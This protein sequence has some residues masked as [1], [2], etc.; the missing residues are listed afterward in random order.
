MRG[1]SRLSDYLV[2]TAACGPAAARV[3]AQRAPS[4]RA[5]AATSS[6]PLPC[7]RSRCCGRP[8]RRG[9]GCRTRRRCFC[10]PLTS[11]LLLNLNPPNVAPP[12]CILFSRSTISFY[13]SPVS[14]N[15]CCCRMFFFLFVVELVPRPLLLRA[16][17]TPRTNKN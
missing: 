10:C 15:I 12:K 17:H 13:V 3:S 14:P 8:R 4:A 5:A 1:M 11:F 7:H 6:P 9:P 16:K 2:R